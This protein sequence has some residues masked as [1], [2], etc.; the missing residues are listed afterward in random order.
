MQATYR[1]DP[2]GF[3]A[4]VLG[5]PP[6]WW[7]QEEICRSIL[8]YRITVV[9]SGNAVGKDYLL[10]G[11]IP[12]YGF[13]RP[14]SL[15]MVT[16]VSQTLLGSVTFKE[17]GRAV[18]GSPL[19]RELGFRVSAGV[20][21]SPQ[22]LVFRPGWHVLGFNTT[23][24]ERLSGQHAGDLLAVINEGS[25][26][27]DEIF[28]AVDSWAYSRLLV[29]G[30][31]LRPDGRFVDLIRQAEH[32]RRDGVPKHRAVNA[33][34]IPSTD[35]PHAH[36]ERSPCGLADRTWLEAQTRQYGPDSQWV[37][38][39]I[40]AE[41]P[42]VAEDSLIPERWLDGCA[43]AARAIPPAGHPVLATR[44]IA[45]DLGEGV[46]RDSSCVLVRDDWGIVDVTFGN[47]LGLPEAAECIARKAWEH[48]VP[49]ERI[50]YDRVGI[51]RDFPLHLQR[52]GLEG[53]LGYA[54]AGKPRS[55]D[56]T[57]LRSEAAW[58]LRQRLDPQWLPGG[59]GAGK[60]VFVIPRGPYWPRLREELRT[61]TYAIRGRKTRLIPKE[62]HAIA[63]GHS[64]DL[65]DALMQSFAFD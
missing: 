2:I 18:S 17:V 43:A 21:A 19:F 47:T 53:C 57:N 22:T 10:G 15:T 27:E 60:P 11:L 51:G 26:V 64:P 1:D 33:I 55:S 65:A 32:D 42:T 56:Y 24:V 16:G 48:G 58:R 13:T 49:P 46:G 36:L 3:N 12:W 7:R 20:K 34:R 63:L 38:S 25:G 30:N 39:H 61:L 40:K 29:T 37:R 23:N 52:R 9:Y 59:P 62:D 41:I 6:Y 8:D 45:C 5:R 44:R 14:N 4:D 50:T 28:D 35:S 31:P 54:G